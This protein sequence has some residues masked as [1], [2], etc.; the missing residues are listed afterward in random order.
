MA[1]AALSKSDRTRRL[2][3]W[4]MPVVVAGAVAIAAVVATGSASGAAPNL[5]SRTAALGSWMTYLVPTRAIPIRGRTHQRGF[6]A[7]VLGCTITIG[8]IRRVQ[9][10][11]TAAVRTYQ[12]AL[13]L[14]ESTANAGPL[15]GTADL[16]VGLAGVLLER[17][18]LPSAAE[19]LTL[20][21]Q[22]G[23]HNGLAQNAYRWQVDSS[24]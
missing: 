15:G 5:P 14:T 16:R 18:E 3:T 1:T 20:R 9:G 11:L 23:D 4:A 22:L 13:E 21:R 12:R 8:D 10:Q 24:G 6:L 2:L 19:Q 17:N 7:D